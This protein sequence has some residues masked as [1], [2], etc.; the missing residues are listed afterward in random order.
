MGNGGQLLPALSCPPLPRDLLRRACT[1]DT[2][3]TEGKRVGKRTVYE[4]EFIDMDDR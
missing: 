1:R 2:E 4:R 3:G